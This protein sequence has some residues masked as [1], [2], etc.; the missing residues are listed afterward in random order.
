MIALALS[1]CEVTINPDGSKTYSFNKTEAIE[2]IEVIEIY[3]DK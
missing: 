1:S 3:S 2:A